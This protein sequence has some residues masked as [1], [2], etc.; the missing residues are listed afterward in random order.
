MKKRRHSILPMFSAQLTATVSVAIVLL[1]L[2]IVALA[3][4]AAR[5]AAREIREQSGFVVVMDYDAD[6]AQIR[7]LK[8]LWINAPYVADVK[9]AGADEVMRRWREMMGTD[10]LPDEEELGGNPFAPEFEVNLRD[11]YTDPDS[12]DSVIASVSRLPGVAEVKP[13]GD[14]VAEVNRSVRSVML[15]LLVIAGALLMISFVLINN[16]VRLSIYSHR[17]LIHTMKLVGATAG[18]IRRPFVVRHI[19]G[20][21]VS[22]LISSALLAAMLWYLTS[23][24]PG[25]PSLI[26]WSA[27][28]YV[29]GAMFV[30][31]ALLSGLAA[32][33]SATRF[34]RYSY[35]DL[36]D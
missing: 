10:D 3:G 30:G 8:S 7:A 18:F 29:F 27:A 31:G 22:A 23:I 1:I 19:V 20:G 36:F 12:V 24:E 28:G 34:I 14:T 4:I 9:Y 13:F 11:I 35:D 16:T 33:V 17:F 21:L 2:G 25:L 32:A 5:T 15:I 6:D 26:P